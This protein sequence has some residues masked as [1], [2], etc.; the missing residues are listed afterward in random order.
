MDRVDGAPA[1]YPGTSHS[2]ADY[3][4]LKMG[5]RPDIEEE[6]RDHDDL[7]DL[8]SAGVGA[9]G[10]ERRIGLQEDMI[11]RREEMLARDRDRQEF[12]KQI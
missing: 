4:D 7:Q 9:A 3:D 1:K 10:N 12:K 8:E 6:P 11:R 5:P 2:H